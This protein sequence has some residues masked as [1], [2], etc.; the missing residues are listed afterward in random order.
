M[1]IWKNLQ[2]VFRG[3]RPPCA[4]CPYRLGLVK[5]PVSPCPD[6]RMS[7]YRTYDTLTRARVNF[8]A[9]WRGGVFRDG[10]DDGKIFRR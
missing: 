8:P 4:D 3:V 7:G 6:C 2:R 10:A 5:F 1:S 9:G